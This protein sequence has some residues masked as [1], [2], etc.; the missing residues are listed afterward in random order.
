MNLGSPW[1]LFED[2]YILGF[3]ID[4][5]LKKKKVSLNVI[6]VIWVSGFQSLFFFFGIHSQKESILHHDLVSSLNMNTL[7]FILT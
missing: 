6:W 1:I 2:I 4:D 5:I 7:I 3:H